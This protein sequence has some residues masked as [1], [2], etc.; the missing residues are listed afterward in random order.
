MINIVIRG[1][2]SDPFQPRGLVE[3][4]ETYE[5]FVGQYGMLMTSALFLMSLYTPSLPEGESV[6]TYRV[7]VR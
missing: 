2:K 5:K 6:C 3:P 1:W 4:L 7:Y